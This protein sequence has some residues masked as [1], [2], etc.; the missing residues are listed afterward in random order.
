MSTADTGH[1]PGHEDGGHLTAAREKIL[2]ATLTHV[3]FD[4]WS[5][6]ALEAGM[7]DSGVAGPVARLA[8]QG[9]LA[10]L[11]EYYAQYADDRMLAALDQDALAAMKIRARIAHVVRLRLEQAAGEREAIRALMSWLAQP[12]HQPL[13]VRCLY[14]TVDAMW[15]GVGDTSTD[16]SFYS[17]RATLAAV[18]AAT[19]FYWLDDKSEDFADTW[20]FLDRRLDD[21]MGIE[22]A[23]A[24]LREVTGRLPDP[25][26]ILRDIASRRPPRY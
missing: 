7:R 15:H 1:E 13:A 17:K 25:F 10:E 12:V 5:A 6:A 11:A 22:R 2:L 9:G 4:G 20:G 21:V 18:V 24:R 23:K 3:P 8:F 14:R 19:V 26:R 16:F